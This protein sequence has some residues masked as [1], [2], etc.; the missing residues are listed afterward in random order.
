MMMMVEKND[1]NTTT[2]MTTDTNENDRHHTAMVQR[3]VARMVV[4]MVIATCSHYSEMADRA[5]MD[6]KQYLERVKNH[7]HY[8]ATTTTTTRNN[9]SSSSSNNNNNNNTTT[10]ASTNKNSYDKVMLLGDPMTV[11]IELMSL[12]LGQIHSDRNHKT[13]SSLGYTSQY[14]DPS[15]TS[16]FLL[17][18]KRRPLDEIT[19]CPKILTFITNHIFTDCIHLFQEQEDPTTII[20]LS[21]LTTQLVHRILCPHHNSATIHGLSTLRAKPYIAAAELLNLFVIRLSVYYDNVIDDDNNNNND[22]PSRSNDVITVLSRCLSIAC[23]VLSPITTSSSSTTTTISS[24]SPN[25]DGSLAIRDACYGVIATLSRC[26]KFVLHHQGYLF[27][28]GNAA[29]QRRSVGHTSRSGGVDFINIDTAALLFACTTYEEERLRPRAVAALD[30]MLTAYR[31]LLSTL[32][33]PVPTPI[34][35]GDIPDAAMEEVGTK[36]SDPQVDTMTNPWAVSSSMD[37]IDQQPT[38][39]NH[40][41]LS[42]LLRQLLWSVVRRQ[43]STT[44]CRIAAARWSSDLWKE[45][46]VLN[47]CHM[48]CFLSGDSDSTVASIA[49]DGI[50]LPNELVGGDD[51]VSVTDKIP[52]HTSGHKFPDFSAFTD[53]MFPGKNDKKSQHCYWDFSYA[54]KAATLRCTLYCLLDDFYC[55]NTDVGVIRYVSALTMTLE[56]VAKVS[57]QMINDTSVQRTFSIDLLDECSACLLTTLSVSSLA[58][59]QLVQGK[60]SSLLGFG[61]I[62]I[63]HLCV[64]TN[65]SRSRRYLAGA[66]GQLLLDSNLWNGNGSSWVRET[67]LHS[68]LTTCDSSIREMEKR[69]PTLS[70]V[71][72]SAFL[73]AYIIRALQSR[74]D[75]SSDTTETTE[76]WSLAANILESFGRG[77]VH[78]EDIIS[79]ACSDSLSIALSRDE[80][81]VPLLN[82]RFHQCMVSILTNLAQALT[83][84]G[85]SD[86]V[87]PTRTLKLAKA[88]G[89]CLATTCIDVHNVKSTIG[90][91]SARFNCID[92]L[93]ELLGSM[94]SRKTEE[95]SIV[96]G[97][98]L[99]DVADADITTSIE[100]T[101]HSSLCDWPTEFDESFV[102]ELP[103]QEQIL[104]ILLRKVFKAASPHKRVACAPALLAIVARGAHRVRLNF[105]ILNLDQ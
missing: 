6:L 9:T 24:I 77:L 52:F 71:H 5:I 13:I 22:H 97:E 105:G 76:C 103:S 41:S 99:A 67:M 36:I 57:N 69:N 35:N 46:D 62:N 85:H 75:G 50:G 26:T 28:C 104:Y 19:Q 30:A 51:D 93:F 23:T 61:V 84:Y 59:R 87:N 49:R 31:R 25:S 38:V 21:H 81:D 55:S 83:K 48:L 54:G 63:P 34:H 96:V 18:R 33:T 1:A 8:T 89:F 12:C 56:E 14:D 94:A 7:H 100:S 65:S 2:T 45:V 17:Q 60:D 11:A 74:N 39:V 37:I 43:P 101:V 64:S 73:G 68:T 91:E 10:T 70:R 3:N 78:D 42:H 27:G 95:I 82:V 102:K 20:I 80:I 88:C 4:L 66:Y 32:M 79:N 16:S 92:S 90:L 58:R 15:V 98:A 40:T 44:A 47:A 86:T 29:I 72:G 53:M